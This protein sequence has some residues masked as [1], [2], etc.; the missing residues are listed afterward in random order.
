MATYTKVFT[1]NAGRSRSGLSSVR[2]TVNNGTTWLTS[3]ITEPIAAS[4]IYKVSVILDTTF[5]G[6]I[7]FDT[8]DGGNPRLASE[9]INPVGTAQIDLT[10]A[11]P[12]RS[13]DDVTAPT[14]GDALLGSWTEAF[15]KESTNPATRTYTKKLPDN[16][17]P[18]RTFDLAVDGNGNVTAR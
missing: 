17:G 12:I 6:S 4:G 3:G 8:N 10:A 16:S 2:Y 7:T 18:V 11:I 14:V 9:A 15:A 1:F 5:S 13:Q